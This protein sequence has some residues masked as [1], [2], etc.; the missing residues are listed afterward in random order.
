MQKGGACSVARKKLPNDV[1]IQVEE[2]QA[3][4]RDSIEETKK[5]AAES[6]RLIRRHRDETAAPRPPNPAR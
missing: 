4:L 3:A 1:L 6:D 2:T 5:L